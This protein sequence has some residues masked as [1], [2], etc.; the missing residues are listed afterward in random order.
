MKAT[1]FYSAQQQQVRRDCGD[2]YDCFIDGEQYTE[3]MTQQGEHKSKYADAVI[4]MVKDNLPAKNSELE[5][6]PFADTS[7]LTITIK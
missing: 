1:F 4:V 2:N 3:V 6:V 7:S 5:L